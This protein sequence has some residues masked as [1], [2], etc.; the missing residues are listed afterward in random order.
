MYYLERLHSHHGTEL[1]END[2]LQ[3]GGGCETRPNGEESSPESE[4]SFLGGNLDHTV[5]GVVV[6]GLFSLVHQ[7][8]S[9]HVKGSNGT[10]HEESGRNGGEETGGQGLL[11]ESSQL[12]DVLLGLIVDSHLRTVQDHGTGNVGVNLKKK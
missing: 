1:F 3:C 4:G 8:C 10:G 11:F 9:D 5:D 6:N 2:Q 12:D 7:S